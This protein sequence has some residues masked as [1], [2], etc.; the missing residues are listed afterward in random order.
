VLLTVG[1]CVRYACGCCTCCCRHVI[2]IERLLASSSGRYPKPVRSKWE[3]QPRVPKFTEASAARTLTKA[4]RPVS[5]RSKKF[6]TRLAKPARPQIEAPA[7]ADMGPPLPPRKPELA[8]IKSPPTAESPPPLPPR[9]TSAG[10]SREHA[11]E[12]NGKFM[13]AKKRQSAREFTRL[14]ARTF[15]A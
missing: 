10:D 8:H 15:A 1:T 4:S 13:A 9:K 11:V 14:Q 12:P 5:K 2:L 7:S 3:S 6:K